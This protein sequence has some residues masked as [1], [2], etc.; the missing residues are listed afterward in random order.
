MRKAAK[1]V[2]GG[3]RTGT[4]QYTGEL[5]SGLGTATGTLED[6]LRQAIGSISSGQGQAVGA[7]QGGMAP[8]QR[9]FGEYAP[10]VAQYVGAITGAPG[11]M[12]A[13][14]ASPA[15]QSEQYQQGQGTE[16][17]ARKG[18]GSGQVGQTQTDL[19]DYIDNLFN[20]QFYGQY[21]PS[22]QPALTGAG[23]AASGLLSGGTS[24]ADLLSRGGTDIGRLLA[25]AGSD[26]SNLQYGTA[27]D[28]AKALM[29]QATGIGQTQAQS[30]MG[31]QQAQQTAGGNI[32]GALF[33]LGGLGTNIYKALNQPQPISVA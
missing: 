12:E 23:Q 26:I 11:A 15:Y 5:Q 27:S 32:L 14:K 8:F 28:I 33:G 7:L 30:L 6:Y 16:A 3:L 24:L 25:G 17:L 10:A 9:L 18:I 31:Q 4:S 2:I 29:G 22:F 21:L 13:W 19:A 20:Q 1:D